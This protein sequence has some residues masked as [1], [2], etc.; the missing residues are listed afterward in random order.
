MGSERTNSL[1]LL[2]SPPWPSDQS[3]AKEFCDERSRL[4]VLASFDLDGVSGDPELVRL[5][6]FA[7]KL[8][9]APS[10]SV[11]LVEE[12]RQRFIASEG[13]DI[14]ETPRSTS[15]CAQ[16]MLGDD[17][18]EV[19]DA[20][21][22][23]RFQDYAL[24]REASHL[25]FY[26]GAP[27]ISS[28]GAPMGALC[29]TDTKARTQGLSEFQRDGLIVLAD[30]VKRRL[31]AHRQAHLAVFELKESA[32]RVQ[33]ILDGVPD[34]AWSAAP[35]PVFD[36]FN[37][38][39][40]EVTGGAPP[41]SVDDWR[42]FIHPDD[43]EASLAKFE[44]AMMS[45][46][47]FADEW[48]LRQADGSYRYVIS[49]AVPS[50]DDPATARWFGT[51]TDIDD[52]YRM[53]Q[54]RELLAGE[55]AHRIKNIFSVI[56]GLISLRSRGDE[57]NQKFAEELN[58]NL[59]ALARA[60]EFAMPVSGSRGETLADLLRVLMA[61]YGADGS[62]VVSIVGDNVNFGGGAATPLA[63]IFHELATNAAK[64]GA[65]SAPAGRVAIDIAEAGDDVAI[66]WRESGGPETAEPQETGFG[67][68]LISMAIDHQ[69][70]G[71]M[72]QDW[73]KSGLIITIRVPRERLT[74]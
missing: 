14:A 26:V 42:A 66:T 62:D 63:L 10:A 44:K 65:L 71:T 29:V 27:L 48:R 56:T 33:F 34:I 13:L 49:R 61:P 52:R 58:T 50:T 40:T 57:A 19:L 16:T 21:S 28:E 30:A 37:A 69:L 36:N 2:D 31:E 7:A 46:S 38:R 59:R 70:G 15:F 1:T 43:F 41:S 55:L 17:L 23:A 5:V 35:G 39:F 74:Q 3:P 11:S 60:Q 53:S 22:D 72:T 64:Y 54:E 12:E 73:Q 68:R 6:K 51:L 25:R 9:D 47:E 67:S 8:C 18:L 32:E 20:A 4:R 24:V 45:A